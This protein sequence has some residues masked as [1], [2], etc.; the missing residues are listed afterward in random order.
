VNPVSVI[1]VG[2]SP[3]QTELTVKDL[4]LRP[5]LA[6]ATR[7][8]GRC[9]VIIPR[10]ESRAGAVDF[11][12]VRLHLVSGSNRPRF[13]HSA[14]RAI[15]RVAAERVDMVGRQILM[16]SDPL[17]ALAVEL[18]RTRRIWPHLVHIQGGVLSPGPEYGN[19]L[20][21]W[22][23]GT[24]ARST[25]RRADGIRVVS[26]LLRMAV[27]GVCD[28]PV[29][30]IGSRVDTAQFS[31][32]IDSRCEEQVPW[33]G[34]NRPYAIMVGA[35][36]ARKNHATVVQAWRSV[37]DV[38]PEARLVI[39][40]EGDRRPALEAL[41]ARLGLGAHVAL[42]GSVNHPDVVDWLAG[43]QCLLHPS[44]SEGQ[45]RAVLEAMACGIPV[46]CSDIPEHRELV[47]AEVGRLVQTDD[48]TAWAA[49]ALRLLT[50]YPSAVAMG[51]RARRFVVERHGFDAGMDRYADFVRRTAGELLHAS[52]G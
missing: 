49:T 25:V 13:L 38:V 17:A 4:N 42:L 27:A 37:V 48:H 28:R 12:Q 41:I 10:G 34:P 3:W 23:L 46:V 18:S 50:D 7:L 1:V 39:L 15:D 5:M 35:L 11:G 9:D 52:S 43:S 29:E 44:W 26:E 32:Q 45:P 20:K 30:M 19:R 24:V 8:G 36:A 2:S 14:R 40:G 22:A 21:R 6:L 51:Q 16:S 33:A 47:N 31:P